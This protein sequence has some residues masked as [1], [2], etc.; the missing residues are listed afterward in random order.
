[1]QIKKDGKDSGGNE[2]SEL[3]I[4]VKEKEDI[5]GLNVVIKM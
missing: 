5:F 1:M 4:V 3:I 2:G